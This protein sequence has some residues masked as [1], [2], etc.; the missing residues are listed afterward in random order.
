MAVLRD[1]DLLLD[2][3]KVLWGQGADPAAIRARRPKLAAF[4][5]Q[6][7]E[8][9]RGLIQPAVCYERV[10]V[11]ELRH[12]RLALGSAELRAGQGGYLAGP[13]V[14]Q[15]LAGA[16]EVVVAVCTVGEG[17]GK[18]SSEIFASDPVR[19]LALDGLASAAAEALG[20]AACRRF[21]AMA[22]AEGQM[23]SIPLN[24]GM[25][26]WPLQEG[27]RQVFGLVDTKDI[28]VRLNGD[29]GL[30]TPL[31]SLSLVMGFGRDLDRT[32]RSC[33]YCAMSETCRYKDHYQGIGSRE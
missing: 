9:S 10:P 24:P 12:E 5:E 33:D 21:E 14:A 22:A 13:L 27:Q 3:D 25:V 4:A 28:G 15:H 29:S 6:V 7:I 19:G 1:W 11:K 30:M 2:A 23:T 8:E 17:L 26:G 18:L 32:G 31:K 20:E 16:Q